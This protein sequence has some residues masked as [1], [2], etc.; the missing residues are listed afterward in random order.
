MEKALYWIWFSNLSKM[1]KNAK[2]YLLETF[3]NAENVYNCTDFSNISYL[4]LK[5]KTILMNKNLENA[6]RIIERANEL[7][8]QIIPFDSPDYP[9][10]LREIHNP[11]YVL[12]AK[13]TLPD[14]DSQLF[15]AIVGTRYCTDY[16]ISAAKQFAG[17]FAENGVVTV[18]GMA[19]GIDS[20][21]AMSSMNH[22]GK[23]IAVLGCG[24]DICYPP[25]NIALMEQIAEKGLLLSEFPPE[26]PPLPHHFP[27]RNRII[28]GLSH[29]I[30][31]IESGKK[32]GSLITANLALEQGK[33]VFAVPGSIFH[34][35]SE[36]TNQII[37]R[38]NARAV[39]C[40]QDILDE[41][42]YSFS[43]EKQEPVITSSPQEITEVH[44]KEFDGLSESEE[45]IAKLLLSGPLHAD[46]IKRLCGL[47]ASEL[48]T[49]LSML[50]FSGHIERESGN[51]YKLKL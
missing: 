39:T 22:N 29:G 26:S 44:I 10:S 18:S 9:K 43:F 11:P 41:Y 12:Y 19:R 4:S 7:D 51:I 45:K 25:E 16:G 48:T 5:D 3:D 40:A 17:G 21:A 27:M 47:D 33:D 30:L 13:G 36:G 42:A 28:S 1:D 34:K 2:M 37:S 23:T 20:E 8:I 6:E 50:E 46:E 38:G 14:W 15:I 32:G 31:V 49:T 35:E 24:V